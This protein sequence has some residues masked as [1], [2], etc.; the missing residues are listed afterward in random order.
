MIEIKPFESKHAAQWETFVAAAN[1]GTMFQTRKFLSYHPTGRFAD[2]SLMFYE[3]DKLVAVL[4][5]V[6][7]TTNDVQTFHSHTGASYGGFMTA[8]ELSIKQAFDLTEALMSYAR[9]EKFGRV[10]LTHPPSIY[11]HVASD[12]IDFALFKNGFHYLKREISSV[13]SLGV[14]ADELLATYKPEVRTAI[15]KARKLGVEIRETESEKD[16][17]AYYKILKKNLELRH[18]VSPTHTLDE[19][20][21]LKS[22]FPEKIRLFAAFAENKLLAGVLNFDAN[23]R[24]TLAFYISHN[25]DE[26]QY[27]PLNLLFYELMKTYIAEGYAYLDFGI[28]T[29]N[30][31]PNWGLGR[32][33]ESFGARG[34][35][36]D[37]WEIYL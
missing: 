23:S 20:F 35:F 7:R 6:R 19:V 17:E 26:Q 25:H 30:M 4:P 31:E 16:Y 12:Y 13:V 29:V 1:N 37:T 27:R 24:V 8:K 34:V 32:F 28:F 2:D 5:A 15:N 36:R 9:K 10:L 14:K 11:S 21:K 3:S 22:L 18:N 33:K